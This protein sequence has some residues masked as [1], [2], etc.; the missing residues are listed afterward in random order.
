MATRSLLFAFALLGI[1]ASLP[2]LTIDLAGTPARVRASDPE[3]KAARLAVE[4]AR[5]RLLGAGRLSNPT[6][7]LEHQGESGLSP[8]TTGLAID[9]SLPLTKRLRLERHLSAQMVEAAALEVR[10]LE[11]RR[12][13]EAQGLVVRLL[14]LEQQRTLRERQSALAK[15]LADFAKER[16]AQG[17]ISPLDAAQA[18]VDS[19]RALLAGRTLQTE[20]VVLLGEL[21][22][23]LGV[24]AGEDLSVA[25]ALPALEMP[26]AA[27]GWGQR[28]DLQG[29]RLREEAART[30]ADLA[31]ARKWEDLTAGLFAAKESQGIPGG[32]RDHA[33]YV[34]FRISLPLPFWNKNEGQIEEKEAGTRRAALETEAL[35]AEIGNEAAAAREE[36]AAHA[37]LA[38][39]TRATL[40]P[41]VR[42]QAERLEA[43]YKV[44]ETDLLSVLRARE[45]LIELEA[46]AL[47]SARDFHLARVRYEEALGVH[48]PAPAPK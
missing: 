5:G 15:E 45:Q 9:Q 16:S 25:G 12:I 28:P 3:L 6:L 41:A 47:G 17:E 48:A 4:E 2:A 13:A 18:L 20:R 24:P 37:A 26:A 42:E 40:L 34:G 1:P 38:A 23:L 19:Q 31:K 22:R 21:K 7:S 43:A 11:R 44:G 39:E 27:G 29:A 32:G 14:A 33:D 36:M 35:A 10:D 46:A 8:R 30:D